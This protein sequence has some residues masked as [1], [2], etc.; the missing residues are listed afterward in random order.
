LDLVLIPASCVIARPRNL[1]IASTK[2]SRDVAFAFPRAS[3]DRFLGQTPPRRRSGSGTSG[4]TGQRTRNRQARY[5]LDRRTMTWERRLREMVMASGALAATACSDNAATS[6]E[7][8]DRL[9]AECCN[10]NPDP[11]CPIAC[12]PGG[13]PDSSSYVLCEQDRTTCEEQD[14][15]YEY[16]PD[17]SIGC[18]SSPEA[19]PDD[20][21]DAHDAAPGDAGDSGDGHD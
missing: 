4:H 20:G 9:D 10:A 16:R 17:G 15:S 11:C 6:V 21:G 7:A 19:G 5:L 12:T 8:G 1:A 14:G 3:G 13:G 18:S 2:E